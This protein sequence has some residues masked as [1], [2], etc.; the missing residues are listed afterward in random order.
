M[1][2]ACLHIAQILV[3]THTHRILGLA[4]RALLIASPTELA[5]QAPAAQLALGLGSAGY[6]TFVDPLLV[7]PQVC[8]ERVVT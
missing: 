7:S 5:P 1:Q 6:R 8:Q 4:F 3:H 2:Q